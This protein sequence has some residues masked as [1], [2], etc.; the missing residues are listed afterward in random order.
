MSAGRGSGRAST[1]KVRH[2]SGVLSYSVDMAP[3]H[4]D[5]P[6]GPSATEGSAAPGPPVQVR[7]ANSRLRVGAFMRAGDGVTMTQVD[8]TTCG[9]TCLLAA[10]L[11]LDPQE[12]QRLGRALASAQAAAA[13][14]VPAQAGPAEQAGARLLAA[15][16]RRQQA[17]QRALNR[18]GLGPLPWPRSLGST[19]WSVAWAMS[20]PL[21][22]AP[23][24]QQMRYRVRWV[25]DRS[26]AWAE[27]VAQLRRHLARGLPV[28]LLV[29]GPLALEA[30]PMV[31]PAHLAGPV[32]L[33]RHYVL[34]LPWAL[35]G[36]AD[37][38]PGCA[39]LYEPGSGSVRALDLLAERDPRA[40]GPR[41]LGGWPRVLALIAPAGPR[42]TIPQ[43]P[44]GPSSSKSRAAGRV[45]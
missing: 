5:Q 38:G 28:L 2:G 16:G 42:D 39:H 12:R 24:A 21:P 6:A 3:A 23:P 33:P 10:R 37:P 7:V 4:H 1:I 17:L 27:E 11:L 30:G 14:A 9:A 40:P 15:L 22:G 36:Q 44:A 31:L 41:E 13:L 29:G 45:G 8:Q 32:T 26:P 25:S 35:I 19:P 18:T 20:A 43:A 34:A